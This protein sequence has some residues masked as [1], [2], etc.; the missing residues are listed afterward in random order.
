MAQ[1]GEN[2]RGALFMMG[3]MAAFTFNDVCMK[4][5]AD[6]LPLAEAVFLRGL[7]T[8]GLMLL[9]ARHLGGV[10]FAVS[11]RDWG[12]IILRSAA[13]VVS[14]WFFITA[15]FN[16]PIANATAILQALP[17]TVTLA[18]AVFLGEPIG[19][20]R[21]M[22]ILIGFV[23][24]LLI[25]KPGAAGFTSYSLYAVFA[26]LAVTVRDLAARRLSPD[27]TSMTVALVSSI[28]VTVAF[29]LGA[30]AQTWMIPRPQVWFTLVG[31]SIFIVGGYLFSVMTMRHGDIAAV[32]PFRYTS[33][34][35]A[36]MLGWVLF[37]EWPDGLT[38]LGAAIVVAT[39]IWTLM[40]ERKLMRG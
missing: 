11:R 4:S 5:L 18:G 23:G 27:V 15:L 6:E 12:L 9:L 38:L 14:A 1:E 34:L 39:G 37:G 29:A 17:L 25:V 32:T 19:W 10:S 3:A 8:G 16:M 20:R 35:W 40:R 31:A 13:E 33:L 2:T 26:V 28:A 36:L 22:A 30:E 7:V 24:V 21:M